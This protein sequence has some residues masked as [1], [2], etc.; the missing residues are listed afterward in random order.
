MGIFQGLPNGQRTGRIEDLEYNGRRIAEAW[1]WDGHWVRIHNRLRNHIITNVSRTFGGWSSI[2]TYQ[3]HGRGR[4]LITVDHSWGSSVL[5]WITATRYMRILV[6]GQQVGAETSQNFT[7]GG[8]S[9]SFT[10]ETIFHHG[11]VI[12]LQ[13]RVTGTDYEGPRTCTVSSFRLYKPPLP[14]R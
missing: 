9:S 1:M 7:T 14:G 11:D 6:N 13:G 10:R 5:Q 3:V 2:I 8:W 12:E 4:G